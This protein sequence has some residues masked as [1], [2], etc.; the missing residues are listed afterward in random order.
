MLSA[1]GRLSRDMAP[2]HTVWP[3]SARE[4][5]IVRGLTDNIVRFSL[6]PS[7]LIPNEG[8]SAALRLQW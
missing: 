7:H 5:T 1:P 6:L 2:L 4:T 8:F 3:R